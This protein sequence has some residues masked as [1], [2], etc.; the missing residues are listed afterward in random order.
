LY[1]VYLYSILAVRCIPQFN[2]SQFFLNY[3]LMQP[4]TLKQICVLLL[5]SLFAFFAPTA[6][7]AQAKKTAP[8]QSPERLQ[9][10]QTALAVKKAATTATADAAQITTA[11]PADKKATRVPLETP[12]NVEGGEERAVEVPAAVKPN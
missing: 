10:R 12:V 5:M 9:A 6:V 4:S 1:S 11:A 8:S 7:F 2:Q 3:Y